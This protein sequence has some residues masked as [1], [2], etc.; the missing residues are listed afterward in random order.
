MRT[1]IIHWLNNTTSKI[2]G[3][4]IADAF[5]K[6]GYGYGYLSEIDWWEEVK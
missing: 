1:F 4:D 6:A 5:N 2:R 3:Y